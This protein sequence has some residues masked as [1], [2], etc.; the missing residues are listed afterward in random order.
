M[1]HKTNWWGVFAIA[2]VAACLLVCAGAGITLRFGPELYSLLQRQSLPR[3]GTAA[4]D[5]TLDKLG[6]GSILFSH[7]RGQPVLLTFSAS[8]CPDCRLEAP[9]QQSLHL[10]HPDLVMLL[11]DSQ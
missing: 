4:P 2:G 7:Y 1:T 10:Q 8:W 3:V 11:V 9:F 5:F 6:G